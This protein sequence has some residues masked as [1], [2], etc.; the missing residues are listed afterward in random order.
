MK[1]LTLIVIL[2]IA[3]ISL[4]FAG[5]V[6]S[7]S[8]APITPYTKRVSLILSPTVSGFLISRLQVTLNM[9]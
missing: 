4:T 5:D 3:I 8:I 6:F 2:L 9:Q 7:F 1:K